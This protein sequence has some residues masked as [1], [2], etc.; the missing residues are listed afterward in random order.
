MN[1]IFGCADFAPLRDGRWPGLEQ[2]QWNAKI[3]ERGPADGIRDRTTGARRD[4]H[5]RWSSCWW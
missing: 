4:S 5:L 3:R 1:S 2:I